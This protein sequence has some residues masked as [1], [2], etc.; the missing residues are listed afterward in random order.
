MRCSRRWWALLLL[1]LIS[2]AHGQTTVLDPLQC[3][4]ADAG[5]VQFDLGASSA[6]VHVSDLG[7]FGG[8]IGSVAGGLTPQDEGYTKPGATYL[9]SNGNPTPYTNPDTG[10]VGVWH[11]SV[12]GSVIFNGVGNYPAS[13]GGGAIAL[14]V[15][16]APGQLGAN[17]LAGK[18]Y[19]R[20]KNAKNNNKPFGNGL[21]QLN[22]D[23]T[24][25]Y[26]NCIP[27]ANYA[28]NGMFGGSFASG[29]RPFS[30]TESS[31]KT[32][33]RFTMGRYDSNT[34]IFTEQVVQQ[35]T[36]FLFDADYDAS[37]Y[38]C[39][40]EDDTDPDSRNP[41]VAFGT[42]IGT[43]TGAL[44]GE[45]YE[46]E[47]FYNLLPGET[48]PS[49]AAAQGCDISGNY[50]F[51]HYWNEQPG[52]YGIGTSNLYQDQLYNGV[53]PTAQAL[54]NCDSYKKNVCLHTKGRDYSLDPSDPLYEGYETI[55]NTGRDKETQ[56]VFK[57]G[58]ECMLAAVGEYDQMII[59]DVSV[60]GVAPDLV[61]SADLNNRGDLQYEGRSWTGFCAA[62]F[63]DNTD[64]PDD[65]NTMTD[66]Q[67]SRTIG[68][69]YKDVAHADILFEV[70]CCH[71]G[72]RNLVFA[73]QA[74]SF[75][76]ECPSPPPPVP[77]E[78]PPPNAPC[79]NK[80]PVPID[81]DPA[82]NPE[83]QLWECADEYKGGTYINNDGSV[84]AARQANLVTDASSYLYGCTEITHPTHP[85]SGGG[86]V[87][88]SSSTSGNSDNDKDIFLLTNGYIIFTRVGTYNLEHEIDLKISLVPDA[89]MKTWSSEM[90]NKC[91]RPFA[92][93]DIITWGGVAA[94]NVAK[95]IFCLGSA[96]GVNQLAGT[97]NGLSANGCEFKFD[98]LYHGTTNPM[99]I[100][101]NYLTFYD[102]DGEPPGN[103][104]CREIV[105]VYETDQLQLAGDG[106]TEVTAGVFPDT[107][108][109]YGYGTGRNI[110][111]IGS[112]TNGARD[113]PAEAWP[114]IAS[115][116]I[117]D[118]SSIHMILGADFFGASPTS[119]GYC[120]SHYM[121]SMPFTCPPPSAPP[122]AIP[123]SPPPP[124]P[125]PT[126]FAPPAPPV[127]RLDCI[128]F[129]GRA[130]LNGQSSGYLIENQNDNSIGPF[131]SKAYSW[132][133]SVLSPNLMPVYVSPLSDTVDDNN[134]GGRMFDGRM[135]L[136][137]DQPDG[138]RDYGVACTGS[139]F[140]TAN[141]A[142]DVHVS[143]EIAV[144]ARNNRHYFFF[145]LNAAA[146]ETGVVPD[147]VWIYIHGDNAASSTPMLPIS[148]YASTTSYMYCTNQA[149][150]TCTDATL[151]A[152]AIK[153]DGGGESHEAPNGLYTAFCPVS[154]TYPYILVVRQTSGSSVC[155][156][157]A[158]ICM[159]HPPSPPPPT[160]PPPSPPPLPPPTPPLPSPPPP[161]PPPPSPPPRPP[162]PSPPPAP[163]PPS[164]PPPTPPPPTP[165][166]PSPPPSP[167]PPI[168]PPL[169]PPPSPPP[170]SPPP[171]RSAPILPPP[172]PESP[173]P[174]PPPPSPALPPPPTPSP[175]P[176]PI[177]PGETWS[178]K[179]GE[180]RTINPTPCVR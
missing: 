109:V 115:M 73:G 18:T 170:P 83:V 63:G 64:N 74:P 38:C 102:V 160:P 167:P 128:G 50:K 37:P 11:E 125:P 23:N 177:G 75:S 90:A 133:S 131:G 140:N 85:V 84:N 178:D 134:N 173:T 27:D 105:S 132:M 150:A 154:T 21:A 31:Q 28:G 59:S 138:S 121:T 87:G 104:E 111:G 49:S 130:A 70:E 95:G 88:L 169:P 127:E 71:Y 24:Q 72:G 6:Y 123:P 1:Q 99:Q 159:H 107:N 113:P 62:T 120:F 17:D 12:Q 106:V 98:Y 22:I 45:S 124:S 29:Y 180:H 97:N 101:R 5:L 26:D 77:P 139:S 20:P 86:F 76:V 163:P 94:T 40:W 151:G 126:P 137:V 122:P 129:N 119:R 146:F 147:G 80:W 67:K 164:P 158:E 136:L 176:P 89:S 25:T 36:M 4:P 53:L 2:R 42:D 142:G 35:W 32:I 54:N 3:I 161:T 114:A 175:P 46:D 65:V 58:R 66:L 15:T 118:Q 145:H 13:Y 143:A 10:Q 60:Q 148:V 168:P 51:N 48:P 100:D 103:F 92:G 144:P 69:I 34:G 19:Y 153:C 57:N 156:N 116:D 16:I 96:V 9:D 55:C 112:L 155:I 68:L 141:A 79:G 7:N 93:N 179:Y 108:I 8:Q 152:S 30:W 117:R 174:S 41:D 172:P 78:A 149:D 166:P 110:N 171:P 81:F 43:S 44:S 82:T 33:Y 61:H 135:F 157:E 91:V 162:P 56:Q 47:C 165:P 39:R 52:A 14:R